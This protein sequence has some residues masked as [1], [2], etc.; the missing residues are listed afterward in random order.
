[1]NNKYL[2]VNTGS[3]S[4]KYALYDDNGEIA[5]FHFE[6]DGSGHVVTVRVGDKKEVMKISSVNF[7][8]SIKYLVEILISKK[9]ISE[10]K[11]ITCIS[12][13]ILA[14]GKYFQSNKTIDAKYMRNLKPAL[15]K[16]PLHLEMIFAELRKLRDYFGTKMTMVGISDSEFHHT[17]PQKAKNYAI[18][19]DDA[20]KYEIYRYGY[21]GISAQSIVNKLK[22]S[23][24]L[25]SRM[26]VCHIGGGVSVMA[27]KDG[28]SIDT[29][30]GFTPLE[31]VVMA[32]RV[33]DIDP[34]AVI[35]LSEVL[36]LNNMKLRQYLNK[37]CGLLGLSGGFSNDIRELLKADEEGN[38]KAKNALDT[39]VYKIQKYIGSSFVAL[40][41]L[42]AIIFSGT[43]GERSFKMRSRICDGLES[44]GVFLDEEINNCMD[45]VDCTL[46]NKDSKVR[47][48]VV[49]TD[50]V[51]QMAIET[52]RVLAE[53]KI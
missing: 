11:D 26:I 45:G 53:E 30:M 23:G 13:R 34:N 33:G 12:I 29:S 52:K 16:S 38:P 3:A 18:N 10:K 5:F 31:G 6:S 9:I 4:K 28:K 7:D 20:E 41:G 37:K 24:A 21:H 49:R 40:G 15:K 39:Y 51:S 50:E 35:Y 44:L 2:I 25:P 42:D 17:M 47:L 43:I 22:K 32:N 48:E 1:M 27:I 46:N 8:K 19:S 14:P 36:K